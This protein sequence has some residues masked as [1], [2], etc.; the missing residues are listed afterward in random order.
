MSEETRA[1]IERLRAALREELAS[2]KAARI[3]PRDRTVALNKAFRER[4]RLTRRI[5]NLQ[6]SSES[7]V[8]Y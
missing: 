1:A 7:E 2:D 8:S 4:V 3:A 6:R 5:R